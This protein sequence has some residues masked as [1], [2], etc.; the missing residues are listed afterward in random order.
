M[1][2]NMNYVLQFDDRNTKQQKDTKS[3]MMIENAE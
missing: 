2:V 1:V 3:T